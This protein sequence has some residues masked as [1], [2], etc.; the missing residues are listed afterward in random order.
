[1]RP[2]PLPGEANGDPSVSLVLF[3]VFERKAEFAEQSVSLF[4]GL[5]AGHEGDLHTEELR[6]L[7][8]VDLREDDL[9]GDTER[10]VALAVELLVDTLEVADTRQCY[11]D[12]TLE[13]FVHLVGA[14]RYHDADRHAGGGK[15]F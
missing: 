6:D 4:V 5:R 2:C 3:C 1:M 11:S 14:E 8:D 7:V 15:A 10:I 9:F 13:E 12:Q